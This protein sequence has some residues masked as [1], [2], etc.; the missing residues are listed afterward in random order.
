MRAW[1]EGAG[2]NITQVAAAA[3]GSLPQQARHEGWVSP[4]SP[5]HPHSCSYLTI[6]GAP[7]P[8]VGGLLGRTYRPPRAAAAAASVAAAG[9]AS[10]ATSAAAVA[11]ANAAAVATQPNPTARLVFEL[12][13]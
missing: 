4:P 9:G 8:P 7:P 2:L 5:A 10:A 1:Q 12:E 11:R 3:A 6:L 13:A